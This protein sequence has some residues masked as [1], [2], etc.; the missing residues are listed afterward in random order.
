MAASLEGLNGSCLLHRRCRS[1]YNALLRLGPSLE[2]YR[3]LIQNLK[4]SDSIFN[5]PPER[6]AVCKGYFSLSTMSSHLAVFGKMF[7]RF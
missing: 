6:L 5:I 2:Q 7:Q 1:H 3:N 4:K